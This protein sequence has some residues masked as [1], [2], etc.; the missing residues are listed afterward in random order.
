MLSFSK[1]SNQ[2]NGSTTQAQ[3]LRFCCVGALCTFIDWGVFCVSCNVVSYQIAA[4]FGFIVSFMV[5]YILTA[6]WTFKTSPTKKNFA[7]MIVAHILNLFV[8]RMGLLFI[9]VDMLQLNERIA[10]IPTL[11]ASAITS[12]IL[13]KFVF[14]G[15]HPK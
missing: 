1:I 3:F 2:W 7:G 15:A 13:M 10:Y 4:I 11:F 14:K 9:L 8:V 5:N 12:F 6:L